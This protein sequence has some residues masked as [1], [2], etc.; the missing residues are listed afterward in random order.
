MMT[1][2][3][4]RLMK[5]KIKCRINAA[6]NREV[7]PDIIYVFNLPLIKPSQN[8]TSEERQFKL[9]SQTQQSV[10]GYLDLRLIKIK[11][12]N[13]YQ[14]EDLMTQAILTTDAAQ[15]G[16][17][18]IMQIWKTEMIETGRW[19][20][21]Q[22][23]KNINQRE[24]EAVVA[25]NQIHLVR[26]IYKLLEEM[27]IKLTTIH[28]PD[29]QNNK[30]DAINI[31]AWR[32]DYMI[33]PE[34]PSRHELCDNIRGYIP[35]K[36]IE[37]R[38]GKEGSFSISW[39]NEA[40]LLLRP[41]ELIPI[42][43]KK[44]NLEPSVASFLLPSWSYEK[45]KLLLPPILQIINL[46]PTEKVLQMGK[47]LE[48]HLLKL[49]P[50]TNQLDLVAAAELVPITI[51]QMIDKPNWE[52]WRK[53]SVGLTITARYLKLI[54]MDSLSLLGERLDIHVVNAMAWLNELGG[55]TRKSNLIALK[56]HTSVVQGQLS[57]I[58]YISDSPLKNNFH[59]A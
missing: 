37:G 56:T 16:C 12:N 41:I 55:K 51:Q 15:K 40:L 43:L 26:L 34:T 44:M 45:F 38:R 20:K 30:A 10:H 47:S 27:N 13:P 14:L 59:D 17:G 31:L 9:L 36:R 19:Q 58:I 48:S 28:I 11:Q 54:E 39:T 23:L 1:P 25:P 2:L 4:R 29:L 22:H 3:R 8:L 24:T 49:H 42:V 52:T 33:K 18:S 35:Y 46:G 6:V 50:G 7:I 53:R 57:R 21:N 32:G 5:M